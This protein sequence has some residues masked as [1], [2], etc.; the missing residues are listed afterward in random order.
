MSVLDT[1]YA[2]NL[3]CTVSTVTQAGEPWAS[4]L[5][6]GFD[7]DHNLFIRSSRDA[8]HMQNM[9]SNPHVF[10]TLFDST[11]VMGKAYGLYMKCDA[12]ELTDEQE[13]V[14]ALQLMNQRAG[15]P[16][17]DLAKF[18]DGGPK[19]VVRLIPVSAWVNSSA[20]TEAGFIDSRE[21]VPLS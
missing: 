21:E 18:I 16:P 4:P 2:D 17:S 12:T 11:Q 13:I 19:R 7:G 1:F 20:A 10:V 8:Q 15:M 3:Y 5:Y 6:F 9:R 14:Q